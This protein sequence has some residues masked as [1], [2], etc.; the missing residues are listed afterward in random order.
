MLSDHGSVMLH[1][2]A[3]SFMICL[4]IS[5]L[6]L[7]SVFWIAPDFLIV[8]CLVAQLFAFHSSHVFLFSVFLCLLPSF[9]PPL[10]LHLLSL[11]LSSLCPSQSF[12]LSN[13]KCPP[14]PS[15][16]T[17]L[18]STDS[19]ELAHC[20]LPTPVWPP[21]LPPPPPPL[22]LRRERWGQLG[23]EP[24]SLPSSPPRSPQP[25]PPSSQDWPPWADRSVRSPC[26][27]PQR[28]ATSTTSSS[29]T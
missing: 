18:P 6:L 2:A 12:P 27:P 4:I 9:R 8:T 19:T 11:C 26:L 28:P 14:L 23:T 17:P 1:S 25:F 21:L 29:R 7:A 20:R 10:H 24:S 3:C 16:Q 15:T 22:P 5:Y 13:I